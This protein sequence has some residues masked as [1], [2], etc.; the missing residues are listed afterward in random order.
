MRFNLKT[1]KLVIRYITGDLS[2]NESA[3]LERLIASGK[4]NKDELEELTIIYNKTRETDIPVFDT[5][6]VLQKIKTVDKTRFKTHSYHVSKILKIAAVITI[7]IGIGIITMYLLQK[8]TDQ[9]VEITTKKGDKI[10]INLPGNNEMWLN[11]NSKI[12]YPSDFTGSNRIVTIDGEAYF[13][14]TNGFTPVIVNCQGNKIYSTEGAFNIKT[15]KETGEMIITVEKGWISVINESLEEK[16]FL[17]EEGFKGTLNDM[18]PIWVEQNKNL[19]YLA[20]KTGILRFNNNTLK[21]VAETLNEI[22]DVDIKVTGDIKYCF[23]SNVFDNLKIET[24]LKDLKSAFNS[25][26]KTVN[27]MI[28]ISGNSC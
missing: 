17:I 7:G 14:F 5:G 24:I 13:N 15:D 25:N 27:N 8:K 4:L 3:I 1:K 9:Y 19:N 16:P 26:I 21:E 18:V 20:W 22:Y 12:S 11:S 6:D 28:I 10:H 23:Y 2:D